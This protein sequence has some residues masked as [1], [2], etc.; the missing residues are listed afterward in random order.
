MTGVGTICRHHIIGDEP[1]NQKYGELLGCTCVTVNGCGNVS[2]QHYYYYY[3]YYHCVLV[4]E[5]GGL[6]PDQGTSWSNSPD[7]CCSGWSV[8][9]RA[10]EPCG[11]CIC[12]QRIQT[13]VT[14][15]S[16]EED[17]KIEP[18]NQLTS[19]PSWLQ[20]DSTEMIILRRTTLYGL[21]AAG[22]TI[23]LFEA[24]SGSI[25]TCVRPPRSCSW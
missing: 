6:A 20:R 12:P 13:W 14:Q 21:G 10:L 4:H 18:I 16:H 22:G 9:A 8:C 1:W 11:T 25:N 5:N 24:F 23:E 7:M 17:P 15:S 19:Q 3:F 2:Q